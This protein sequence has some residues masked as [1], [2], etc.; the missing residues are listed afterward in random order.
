MKHKLW[1]QSRIFITFFLLIIFV[2]NIFSYL[3]Y[4]LVNSKIR[5]NI[6]ATIT[7]EYQNIIDGIDT[8]KN[9]IFVLPPW[10]MQ[11]LSKE[12]LFC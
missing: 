2:V 7:H 9:T 6:I 1:I 8:Q 3:L 10:E 5:E 4:I 11:E 12:W